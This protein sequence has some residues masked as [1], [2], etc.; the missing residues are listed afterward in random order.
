[1]NTRRICILQPFYVN[2][3]LSDI[4]GLPYT[5]LEE[6]HRALP[7]VFLIETTSSNQ[8]SHCKFHQ[9]QWPPCSQWPRKTIL[10]PKNMTS[11]CK[12]VEVRITHYPDS[13]P[14]SASSGSDLQGVRGH[15]HLNWSYS[16]SYFRGRLKK[17]TRMIPNEVNNRDWT[18]QVAFHEFFLR[19]KGGK[20]FSGN[21][22]FF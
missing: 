21:C 3:A 7:G 10:G 1:M 12:W 14:F 6:E 4:H 11:S 2:I 20:L 5:S 16:L 15:K 17:R 8:Y 13:N 19:W 9:Q 22:S 18:R